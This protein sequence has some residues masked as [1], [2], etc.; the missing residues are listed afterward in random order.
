MSSIRRSKKISID[1]II[2]TQCPSATLNATHFEKIR[3]SMFASYWSK[4]YVRNVRGELVIVPESR[5]QICWLY[6]I[7]NLDGS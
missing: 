4:R 3:L 6:I 7:L 5:M 1:D 2:L